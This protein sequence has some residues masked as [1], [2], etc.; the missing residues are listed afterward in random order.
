M[1]EYISLYFGNTFAIESYEMLELDRQEGE[2]CFEILAV[3]GYLR[4]L[5]DFTALAH[6]TRT[7]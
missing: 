3:K 6:S 2:A 5:R 4:T 7:V 1:F